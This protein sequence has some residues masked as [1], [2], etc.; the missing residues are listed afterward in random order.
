MFSLVF[1][2]R[3]AMAHRLRWCG[4]EKCALPHG[5]NEIVRARL[6][7]AEAGRLDGQANMI[8]PFAEAKRQWHAWIDN[9]VDHTLQLSEDDPLL[10]YF[11]AQEPHRMQKIMTFPGDPTTE[12]L[13]TCFM[14]KISAFLAEAGGRL[15]CAEIQVEETPTN[16]VA[17][18]GDARSILPAGRENEG[19]WARADMSINDL[20][21]KK[22][23]SSLSVRQSAAAGQ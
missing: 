22:V 15:R 17:F 19:W 2:R 20:P 14:S 11:K 10:A 8:E 3:Y 4:S 16:T 21:D 13:A 9:H 7:P 6:V 5:H 12:L 23:V 1:S 18:D